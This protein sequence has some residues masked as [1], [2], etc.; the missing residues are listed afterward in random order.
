MSDLMQKFCHF[1]GERL[2]RRAEGGDK[3]RIWEVN[4]QITDIR[5]RF[6]LP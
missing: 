1:I 4:V 5:L 2:R 3:S 6:G